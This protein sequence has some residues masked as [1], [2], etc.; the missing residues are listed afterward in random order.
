MFIFQVQLQYKM[1]IF[2]R[3]WSFMSK[4]NRKKLSVCY[5]LLFFALCSKNYAYIRY[6]AVWENAKGC[7]VYGYGDD[8]RDHQAN[9]LHEAAIKSLALKSHADQPLFIVEDYKGY[10]GHNQEITKFIHATESTSPLVGLY[11]FFSNCRHETLN[12]EH[13]FA[14]MTSICPILDFEETRD[15][16]EQ[17]VSPDQFATEYKISGNTVVKEFDDIVGKINFLS[18]SNK[19][20]FSSEVIVQKVLKKCPRTFNDLR[21]NPETVAQYLYSHVNQSSRLAVAQDLYYFDAELIDARVAQEISKHID[22]KKIYLFL[23][24]LHIY[25]IGTILENELG[26]ERKFTV[27]RE[28]MVT[29]P[30]T[31]PPTPLSYMQLE[32][33]NNC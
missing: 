29:A 12:A 9:I 30:V 8:H 16:L 23:G 32:M 26:F 14:R 33:L 25:N 7:T 1:F 10:R 17:K 20:S 27:G 5:F 3:N 18:R 28:P 31:R 24:Y 6:I 13:R 4:K 21:N 19:A 22:R 11:D 15:K 2:Q